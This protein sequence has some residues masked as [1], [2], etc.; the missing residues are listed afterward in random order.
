M[1][2]ERSDLNKELFLNAKLVIH[3]SD[4]KYD[5]FGF[6]HMGWYD[7]GKYIDWLEE[8]YNITKKTT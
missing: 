6:Y 2:K 3:K 8:N 5:K 4:K 7:V 1:C